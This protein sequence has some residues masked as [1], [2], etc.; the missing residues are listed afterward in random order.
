MILVDTALEQRADAN[1]P[2]RV[3]LVGAGYQGRGV[4][5]QILTAMTGM[6]LVAVSN[7]T[8]ARARQAYT[9][10]DIH[11]VKQVGTVSELEQAIATDRFAI[12]DD[13]DLLCRAAC[14]DAIIEATGTFEFGAQVALSA[15]EHG[16]HLILSNAELDATLGP[17]L[18][19]YADRAGVVFTDIDG[20]QPGSMMNLHRFVATI[21]Y[22]PVLVGNVKGLLDHYRTPKTQ[23]AWADQHGQTPH[24]VTSFADGTKISMENTVAANATGFPVGQRGMYGPRCAHVTEA[25]DLYPKDELLDTG[26]NDYV[27]GAEPGPGVFVIAYNDHPIKQR[28]TSVLKM[29]DGPFYVFY[30]PYHLP[31]LEVPLTVARAVCFGD[32]TVA[33]L[34]P[35]VCHVLTLAKRDLHSGETLDGLGGF[36]TYGWIDNADVTYRDSLLPFGLSKGAV[37]TRDVPQDQALTFDD[38]VLPKGRLVDR[39]WAEQ[40]EHFGLEASHPMLA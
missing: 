26:L 31:H 18:K 32:A 19:V 5:L 3:A 22:R 36:C 34:G 11:D 15:L 39:L 27:I 24:M 33:P 35:P 1:N 4:A 9:Q 38:V 10:A 23:Q 2:I 13:A 16:K 30:T 12:T 20:D 14:I 6:R 17:I 8:L 37:L 28:Y 21:G 29:G 25:V 40:T 7:R